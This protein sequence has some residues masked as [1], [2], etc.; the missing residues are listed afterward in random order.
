MDYKLDPG[1]LLHINK[2]QWAQNNCSFFY[3]PCSG[4]YKKEYADLSSFKT[5][6]KEIYVVNKT[7]VLVKQ[8]QHDLL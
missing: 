1:R 7:G 3:F 5:C 2:L 6:N 8:K 4:F